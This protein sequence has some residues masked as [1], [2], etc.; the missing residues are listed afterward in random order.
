[1]ILHRLTAIIIAGLLVYS[2]KQTD[3]I[4]TSQISKKAGLIAND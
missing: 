3:N 2:C 1:M 4:E